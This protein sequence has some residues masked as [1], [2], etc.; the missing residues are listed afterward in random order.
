[1]KKG[2]GYSRAGSGHS[3]PKAGRQGKGQNKPDGGS[4]KEARAR[5]P[6]AILPPGADEIL[7]KLVIVHL[8]GA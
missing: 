6:G 7:Q 5:L 3:S 1:M 2:S 4:G 8:V